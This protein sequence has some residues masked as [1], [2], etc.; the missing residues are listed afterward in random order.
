MVPR[1]SDSLSDWSGL[2]G[3]T[4]VVVGGGSGIGRGIAL[5][6][7]AEKMTVVVADVD[8]A[9]ADAVRA[10]VTAAGGLAR[11][12][13]VDA[14][15]A[16]SLGSLALRVERE[17]G[18]VAVLVTTVGAI[19]DRRTAD[20]TDDEWAWMLEAN[21]LAPLRVVRAFLPLLR[22]GT[23]GSH[24]VLTSSLGGLLAPGPDESRGYELGPYVASKHALVAAAELLRRE[25]AADGIGVSVL[26]PTRVA[27]NLVRTS[28]RLRP[29]RCGGSAS[30][31]AAPPGVTAD[32]LP[33]EAV[34][35]LVVR[36]IRANR[37]LVLTHREAWEQVEARHRRLVEDA[38]AADEGAGS[39]T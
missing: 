10:E 11:A 17:E 28:E 19:V 5:G 15:S 25:L 34:G 22:K 26:C 23:K 37:F 4:A 36:A 33:A 31:P 24:V 30:T 12:A 18:G 6:L 20:A 3:R 14:S 8:L 27:G 21:L 39:E 38:R 13:P 32:L 9:A 1:P 7:A 16:E 35:P 2:G 29:A